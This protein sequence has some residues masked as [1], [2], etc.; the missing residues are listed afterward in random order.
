M[1]Q[2]KKWGESPLSG[3]PSETTAGET[4]AQDAAIPA[5]EET[6]DAPELSA[7]EP[8]TAGLPKEDSSGAPGEASAAQ[9]ENVEQE[10][11]PEQQSA[12]DTQNE[13]TEAVAGEPAPVWPQDGWDTPR[14]GDVP[15]TPDASAAP[16]ETAAQAGWYRGARVPGAARPDCDRLACGSWYRGGGSLHH[17]NEPG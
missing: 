5:Q 2:E 7:Q 16:E 17:G 13:Q 12:P 3:E 15:E 4:D 6:P 14:A 1:D 11:E 8:V 10:A 9:P